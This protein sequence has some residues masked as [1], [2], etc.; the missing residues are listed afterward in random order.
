MDSGFLSNLTPAQAEAMTR[1]LC[2]A[3]QKDYLE[4]SRKRLETII[5]TKIRTT[6]IGSLA[7]FEKYFGFLW[8]HGL[9]EEDLTPEQS[10]MKELFIQVRNE[11][12]NNGNNQMRASQNEI[13]NQTI[14]WNRFHIDLP[15]KP[16]KED[17]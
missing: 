8:G 3:R 16:L 15:V 14:S 11:I 4:K 5:C 2:E 1:Q 10:N 17:K 12:L 6:F 13:A 9:N 7:I